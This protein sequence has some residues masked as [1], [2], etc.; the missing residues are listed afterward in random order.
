MY[1]QSDCCGLQPS[2]STCIAGRG[3]ASAAAVWA[4]FRGSQH[5]PVSAQLT[6]QILQ[7]SHLLTLSL[8]NVPNCFLTLKNSTEVR[9]E[10]LI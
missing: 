7:W 5:A 4:A 8:Q 6:L 2:T 9:L 10:F 1:Q 3:Q